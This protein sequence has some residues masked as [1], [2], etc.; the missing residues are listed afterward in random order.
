MSTSAAAFG[1]AGCLASFMGYV[2]FTK[3]LPFISQN[4]QAVFVLGIVIVVV[5]IVI[6]LALAKEEPIIRNIN[7]PKE[8]WIGLLKT[9]IVQAFRMK[10]VTFLI[11]VWWWISTMA[12]STN[13]FY[14][15][16]YV[17]EDV[18]KGDPNAP[19]NSP[20]KD[21]FN[22]GV[23]VGSLVKAFSSI[24]TLIFSPIIPYLIKYAGH[25]FLMLMCMAILGLQLFVVY[26][27]FQAVV[28]T[29]FLGIGNGIPGAI[30]NAVP[31]ILISM[32]VPDAQ[33]G[34]FVGIL[35][36]T[37]VVS[38]MLANFSSSFIMSLCSNLGV[39]IV[40][41][42]IAYGGLWALIGVPFCFLVIIP[43]PKVYQATKNIS[44]Q[45]EKMVKE[46]EQQKF[47]G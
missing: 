38:Q 43:K 13:T 10:K 21:R 28:A 30:Q 5:T 2:P 40:S 24:L 11:L 46:P 17:A 12:S 1:L 22:N 45:E 26:K 18:F 33:M 15:T 41:T 16:D 7:I 42:G 47:E 27:P 44:V 23:R 36:M 19:P 6:T 31:C 35:S 34:V 14:F 20:G 3:F 9:M 32:A 29:Y 25:K 4:Y 8:S 37:Q 39:G